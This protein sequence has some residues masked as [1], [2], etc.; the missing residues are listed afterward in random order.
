M[1]VT[2]KML[3]PDV[4]SPIKLGGYDSDHRLHDNVNTAVVNSGRIDSLMIM[5]L[6]NR[7]RS[8]LNIDV[9]AIKFFQ[10]PSAEKLVDLLVEQSLLAAPAK[11]GWPVGGC[12]QKNS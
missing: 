10:T 5:E 11:E 12:M 7:F 2:N 8:S 6:K 9:P 3:S 4:H 1:N